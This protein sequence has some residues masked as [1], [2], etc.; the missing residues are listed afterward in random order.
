M[1]DYT[2]DFRKSTIYENFRRL[3]SKTLFIHFMKGFLL[4]WTKRT[5]TKAFRRYENIA[6]IAYNWEVYC[7]ILHRFKI[8]YLVYWHHT[9]SGDR[10]SSS[11]STYGGL[12]PVRRAFK[13]GMGLEQTIPM[14]Q[15]LGL[16]RNA[17]KERSQLDEIGVNRCSKS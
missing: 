16:H 11:R 13:V 7:Q 14:S 6:T 9:W 17:H 3:W 1:I 2:F 4:V 10:E 8:L 5:S 15:N 12:L